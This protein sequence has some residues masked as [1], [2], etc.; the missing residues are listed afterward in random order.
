MLARLI[1]MTPRS[2]P[3][4]DTIAYHAAAGL[5]ANG[6]AALAAVGAQ[7]LVRAGVPREVAPKMLG[8]LL[9]SVA[10]NVE[11]LGFPEAL[12]GPV[13][14]GDAGGVEK[15][16]ST[17]D[18]KLPDAVPLYLAAAKAQLPLARAIGEASTESFDAVER[19]IESAQKRST[20][21]GAGPANKA[22]ARESASSSPSQSPATRRSS[23]V[24]NPE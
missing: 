6:A 10:D 17:L 8:P 11:T 18:A 7:L 20:A 16:L 23:A 21:K 14:R 5:V 24:R 19:V 13:R 3:D 22:D 2:I 1:G 4:L 15:H 12:T 9:R